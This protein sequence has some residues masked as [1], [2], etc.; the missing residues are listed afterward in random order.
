[1]GFD[2]IIIFEITNI[3]FIQHMQSRFPYTRERPITNMEKKIKTIKTK[4]FT[5]N[6]RI[7][8]YGLSNFIFKG[9]CLPLNEWLFQL[10]MFG[11]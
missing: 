5:N 6:I 11:L 7:C 3:L 4:Y 1:M 9:M 10:R 2:I 8:P